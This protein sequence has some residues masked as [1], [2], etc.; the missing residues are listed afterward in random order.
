M[1]GQFKLQDPQKYGSLERLSKRSGLSSADLTL[2][3][4]LA[5]AADFQRARLYIEEHVQ[6]AKAMTVRGDEWLSH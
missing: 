6:E 3:P 2:D 1:K 4:S 5:A